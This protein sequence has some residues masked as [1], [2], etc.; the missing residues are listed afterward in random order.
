[1]QI[2]PTADSREPAVLV[3]DDDLDMATE[4]AEGLAADGM[5]SIVTSSAEE[6]LC[7]IR[8]ARGTIRVVVT[9]ISMPGMSGLE[10]A[11]LLRHDLPESEAVAV[12]LISGQT[13]RAEM[14]RAD[15]AG[16]VG[17]LRKPF[18]WED[19]AAAVARANALALSRRCGAAIQTRRCA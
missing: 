17:I 4:L 10:L 14:D 1:M 18:R 2:V 6:A 15:R 13:S 8:A 3:A 12:V 11:R 5:A 16:A 7:A 9:D 19:I